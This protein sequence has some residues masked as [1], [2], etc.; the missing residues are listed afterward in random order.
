MSNWKEEFEKKFKLKDEV[1]KITADEYNDIML[2]ALTFISKIRK[3]DM[4]E[5][6]KMLPEKETINDEDLIIQSDDY[7]MSNVKNFGNKIVDDI[8]QRIKSYYK[9]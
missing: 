6:I 4:D 5:L 2:Y 7:S 8:K 1:K 3:R 9:E